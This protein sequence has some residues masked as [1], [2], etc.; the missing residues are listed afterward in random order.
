MRRWIALLAALLLCLSLAACGQSAK[1]L[2]KEEQ[3]LIGTWSNEYTKVIFNEDGTG[4]FVH[5]MVSYF[6]SKSDFTYTAKD[7]VLTMTVDKVTNETNY[8]IKGDQLTMKNETGES[9]YTREKDAK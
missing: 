1:E 5:S 4:Q 3:T 7:G 6:D 2:S 9:S 8:T